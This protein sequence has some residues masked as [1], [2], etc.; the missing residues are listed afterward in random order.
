MRKDTKEVSTCCTRV[1]NYFKSTM[2]PALWE[3]SQDNLVMCLCKLC[4]WFNII[5]RDEKI[6]LCHT[7]IRYHQVTDTIVFTIHSGIK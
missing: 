1:M 7:F 4:S 6:V 5:L 2:L 3:Q